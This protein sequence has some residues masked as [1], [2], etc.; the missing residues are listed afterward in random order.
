MLSNAT[1]NSSLPPVLVSRFLINLRHA[2][3][4]SF[5][6]GRRTSSTGGALSSLALPTSVLGNTGE[7]LNHGFDEVLP[8]QSVEVDFDNV[9]VGSVAS[10]PADKH[11]NNVTLTA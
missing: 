4:P 7:S 5:L 8:E 9:A 1:A 10:Q 3:Q 6:D 2:G 11:L